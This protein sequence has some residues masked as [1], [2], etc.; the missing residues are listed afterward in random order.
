MAAI[1]KNG[2]VDKLGDYLINTMIHTEQSKWSLFMLVG[3]DILAL[4]MRIMI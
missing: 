1:S 4:M 2:Y 3:V